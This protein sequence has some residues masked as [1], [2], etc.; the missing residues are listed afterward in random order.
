MGETVKLTREEEIELSQKIKEGDK[1]AFDKF[2]LS[3]Q[4]LVYRIAHRCEWGAPFEDLVQGGNIGLIQAVRQYDGTR[5]VP[6]V[7]FGS[8]FIHG[9]VIK[10]LNDY[11]HGIKLPPKIAREL[12][13][14]ERMRAELE[15]DLGRK[16]SDT[17][18]AMSVGYDL[19]DFYEISVVPR[20]VMSYDAQKEVEDGA[21]VVLESIIGD[22]SA[23]L[24]EEKIEN[25]MLLMH[26]DTIL[27][28]MPVRERL[29]LKLRAGMYGREPRTLEQVAS[30]IGVSHEW[31]R[32]IGNSGVVEAR[33]YSS[34][35]I[36]K[37]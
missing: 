26:L 12:V 9:E 35:N 14:I 33:K 18:V 6:F 37:V 8:F 27:G 17:E 24:E 1:K 5:N 13:K 3:N 30:V 15:A 34:V 31:V 19:V 22:E 25:K 28:E 20:V 32:Q 29:V 16:A 2:V 23:E 21:T 4:G 7:V 10:T 11:L 36:S